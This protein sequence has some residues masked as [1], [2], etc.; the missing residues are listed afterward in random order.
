MRIHQIIFALVLIGLVACVDE[1]KEQNAEQTAGTATQAEP[2]ATPDQT[3]EADSPVMVVETFEDLQTL[4]GQD[5]E[6]FYLVNFWA[7]WCKPCVEELPLIEGLHDKMKDQ[8][9]KILLVSID[10]PKELESR[11]IPFVE[12]RKLRSEVVLLAD[13]RMDNWIRAVNEKWDGAIPATVMMYKGKEQFHVGK[14]T[15]EQLYSAIAQL[16]Q[17]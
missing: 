4:Y 3:P 6:T 16:L 11:V 13:K 8:K 17:S 14:F 15:E 5:E 9:L 7:T 12:S 2:Q 10:F 1:Q